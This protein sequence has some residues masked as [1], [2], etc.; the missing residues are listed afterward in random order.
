[1]YPGYLTSC[2]LT[3]EQW[4]GGNMID[5]F[6]WKPK[7]MVTLERGKYG[8]MPFSFLYRELPTDV[9]SEVIKNTGDFLKKNYPDSYLIFLENVQF[10][11]DHM[12]ESQA[13]EAAKTA[14]GDKS[15]LISIYGKTN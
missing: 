8:F 15:K 4:Q 10:S 2:G 7:V 6:S 14:K 5:F 9:L 11:Y 1:M 12:I 13:K 3:W